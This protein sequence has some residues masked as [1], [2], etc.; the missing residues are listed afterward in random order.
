[1]SECANP[2]ELR[3]PALEQPVVS[4]EREE[5]CRVFANQGAGICADK[6]DIVMGK[7]LLNL[8]KRMA[9]LF[10]MLILIAEPRFAS[11]WVVFS[12]A[13]D[14]IERNQLIM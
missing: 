5:V 6:F 3:K 10:R 9:M 7:P 4:G 2:A 13:Q 12:A 11:S 8:T 1:M 14:R